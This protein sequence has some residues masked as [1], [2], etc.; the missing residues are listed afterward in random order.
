ML[1]CRTD[2]VAV[3]AANNALGE[4]FVKKLLAGVRHLA[5]FSLLQGWV[6]MVEVKCLGSDSIAAV[7]T[8]SS[9]FDAIQVFA[10]DTGTEPIV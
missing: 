9:E 10:P 4:F 2:G 1:S 3:S 6:E 7:H 5:D 8:T